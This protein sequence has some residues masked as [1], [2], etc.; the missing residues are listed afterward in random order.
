MPTDTSTACARKP[1][2]IALDSNIFIYFLAAHPEFGED[3]RELLVAIEQTSLNACAS[4]LVHYEVL[5]CS[6][7]SDA[8]AHDITQL[9][10]EVDVTYKPVSRE[11]L[12]SAA[13]LRCDYGC[14]AM[15]SIHLASA[16][17]AKATHFVTND[18]AVLK[19]PVEGIELVALEQARGL[20]EL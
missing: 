13:K 9:L 19:K 18:K 1:T 10:G 4:E 2:V 11:V 16:L 14:G 15:D 12:H 5:S 20:Y 3:A 17:Q 7:V 8:D 6:G